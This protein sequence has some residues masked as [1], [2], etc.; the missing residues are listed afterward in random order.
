MSEKRLSDTDIPETLPRGSPQA[1]RRKGSFRP[2]LRGRLIAAFVLLGMAVSGILSLLLF[3]TAK[4][5]MHRDLKDRLR[6][7]VGVAALCVDVRAHDALVRPDQEGGSAYL[8][9][10]GQL[11]DVQARAKDIHFVYTMREGPDGQIVFVVDAET[12]PEEIA[13]L[14][15]IYTDASSFLQSNFKE[16]AEPVTEDDFYTDRWGTWLTGYAP[17]YDGERRVGVLGMDI[18]ASRIDRYER[19]LLYLFSVAFTVSAL[20]SLALGV[21]L[22]NALAAPVRAVK[23]SVER[24]G[25]GDLAARA[26]VGT[27][28][29]VGQLALAF[30]RMA[31]RLQ[32]TVSRLRTEIESRRKA[33]KTYRSIFESSMEGIF[34]STLEGRFLTVNP[35][36][37]RMLGYDDAQDALRSVTDIGGQVYADA[38]QRKRFIWLLK[39][40]RSVSNY[41]LLLKR[42][43]G[44]PV[45]AELTAS[46]IQGDDGGE[47]IQGVLKDISERVQR[48]E[49]EREKRAARAASEAK[50]EFLANMSHEIRTPMNAIM[51]LADL[52]RRTE[53]SARQEDYL[54]KIQSSSRNLLG[55]INNILDY[56]KIEAGRLELERTPFVLDDVLSHLSGVVTLKAEEKGLEVL[57]STGDDVPQRLV[58]DP[59]RLGQVLVNLCNNAV[60]FTEEGHILVR[61]ERDEGLGD[62]ARGTVGL[63]FAVRDTGIGV[64][65]EKI[66]GL[67]DAFTQMDGSTTRKYGGTGLG[68]TI[69]RQLVRLMGGEMRVDSEEGRGATFTFTAL[70]EAQ[71]EE[72]VKHVLSP[73]EFR[74]MKVLVV[75]DNKLSREIL[76]DYLE[77]FSFRPDLASSA[78]EALEMLEKAAGEAP[79]ELV[80]MDYKMP[81]VDGIEASRHIKSSASLRKVPAV[82]MVTAY[83][84]EDV[85]EAARKAGIDSFLHKPVNQS[86]LFNSIMEVFG[87][88]EFKH[89]SRRPEDYGK[90]SEK[91]RG[92]RLLLAEDNRINQEVA[93]ELLSGEGFSVV[94]ANN[95][96]EAADL[97]LSDEA[98]FDAVLMDVQMP[99]MDGFAAT[100]A[101]RESG[102]PNRDIPVIA[103]TAH[104]LSHQREKCLQ[105]GMNG[106]IAK[107][108]QLDQLFAELEKFVTVSAPPPAEA[109]PSAASEEDEDPWPLE[110]EGIDLQG[111]LKLFRGKK[112]LLKK[113]LG[114][115]RDD[116]RGTG[117]VLREALEAGDREK[118]ERTAH[119]VKGVAA[120]IRAGDLEEAAARLEEGAGAE[121][122]KYELEP[123]VESFTLKLEAVLVSIEG[124]FPRSE[125]GGGGSGESPKAE[126]DLAGFE[127]V[128]PEFRRL[129]EE[130]NVDA[131]DRFEELAAC[132]GG[133]SLDPE[134][135]RMKEF[136]EN[137]EFD[138]ALAVLDDLGERLGVES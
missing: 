135:R 91:I 18:A 124:L 65:S 80:L 100:R 43:D 37:A 4:E 41:A 66:D 15:D 14:G 86:L 11:R 26:P 24:M 57:F 55:I 60:K 25:K 10:R 8:K 130:G 110:A 53:L 49:A 32:S 79:Y 2:G 113:L 116:Y 128:F 5:E 118:I 34:Q 68:L 125:A 22:G 30:N 33:E 82:L 76:A 133:S 23:E 129:L 64:P 77:S 131:E 47:I 95:G 19:K 93:V 122:E 63:R 89:R 94:V 114:D 78:E 13:H 120:N 84:R 48:E 61:I 83:G 31:E 58:G 56:S 21:L 71:A 112:G 40:D 3:Q 138:S 109:L 111:A 29:E 59:L 85:Y 106:H 12:D 96:K 45:Q 72:D 97:V 87:K 88:E 54:K 105:A 67:F 123:L 35:E 119:T 98:A 39:E 9:I 103:L 101:I 102:R 38:D 6:D 74:D 20:F 115:F 127:R 104:A 81:G 28:D 16:I 99:V 75:D 36:L 51:G 117:A 52:M 17:L 107:P 136:L 42:K 92:A 27:S 108:I 69:S 7:V 62:A 121:P 132:L 126:V 73:A 1:D 137:F 44:S 50:S 46:I 134:L 90:A 70:L